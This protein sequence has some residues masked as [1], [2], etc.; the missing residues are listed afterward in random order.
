VHGRATNHDPPV[1]TV[2]Q[3]HA[4]KGRAVV[5]LLVSSSWYARST[6]PAPQ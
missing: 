4:E 3:P 6:G 5:R 2:F 1:T